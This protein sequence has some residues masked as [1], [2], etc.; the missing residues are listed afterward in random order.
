[1]S[2]VLDEV[3]LFVALGGV[4]LLLVVADNVDQFQVLPGEEEAVKVGRVH[5]QNSG[6]VYSMYVRG[7]PI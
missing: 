3:L 4:V 7:V 6:N 1:M 2:A 5:L